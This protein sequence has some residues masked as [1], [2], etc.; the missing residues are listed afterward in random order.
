MSQVLLFTM[1]HVNINYSF[2]TKHL[3]LLFQKSFCLCSGHMFMTYTIISH[4]KSSWHILG[5]TWYH[6][7]SHDPQK[8]LLPF[9][10][11]KN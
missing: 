5:I 3:L 8:H 6:I 2:L 9:L 10:F 4:D 11:I 7:L 1:L